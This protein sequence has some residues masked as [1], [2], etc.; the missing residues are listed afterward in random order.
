[1]VNVATMSSALWSRSVLPHIPCCL[2][3]QFFRRRSRRIRRRRPASC[4]DGWMERFRRVRRETKE[5][6][7]GDGLL[8]TDIFRC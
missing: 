2:P 8:Y 7:P 1:V 5:A 6:Y 4:V 3:G